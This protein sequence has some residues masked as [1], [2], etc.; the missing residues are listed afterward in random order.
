M[1]VLCPTCHGKGSIPDPQCSGT[2]VSYFGQEGETVPYVICQTCGGAGW[3]E[4]LQ[5]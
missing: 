4:S 2:T 5:A 1:K 3:I